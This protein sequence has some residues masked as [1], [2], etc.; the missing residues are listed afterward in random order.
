MTSGLNGILNTEYRLLSRRG[1][2]WLLR[3][4]GFDLLVRAGDNVNAHDF[5]FDGFDRLRAGVSGSLDG[6][7]VSDDDGGD[8]GVTDLD[9]RA[10]EFDV[11]GFEHGIGALNESNQSARFEKSNSLMSHNDFYL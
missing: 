5:A 6:S 7:D 4:D 9:H 3:Q 2:R 8:Q 11:G 1:R 10:G